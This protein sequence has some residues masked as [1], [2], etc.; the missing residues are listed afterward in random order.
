[1]NQPS[2]NRK[3]RWPHW[4]PCVVLAAG[5]F[6]TSGVMVYGQAAP[7]TTVKP[8][9][10]PPKVDPITAG[11]ASSDAAQ[12][13]KAVDTMRALFE[14]DTA[15]AA[16]KFKQ[17]WLKLLLET[18]HY[19]EV[20]DL[21]PKA[22]LNLAADMGA[23]EQ[24]QRAR[25]QA[26]IALG[27][28]E[29]ALANAK[30]LYN[31]ATMKGTAEAIM[32]VVQCLNLNP[33]ADANRLDRFKAQQLLGTNDEPA[34]QAL[35]KGPAVLA[36]IKVDGQQYDAAI[37]QLSGEDYT[38]LISRGNLL[39]LAD[40]PKEA[41]EVFERAYMIADNNQLNAASEN[42]ARAMRAEDGNVAR[43]NAWAL[44]IRPKSAATQPGA[45]TSSTKG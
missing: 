20:L 12:Q 29:Q 16:G 6:V 45:T 36:S 21:S 11:L 39:L 5:F 41:Q 25:V 30:G 38:S 23:V 34:M 8:K 17:E 27:K 7:P 22:I 32:L 18:K 13:Q 33:S 40:R 9:P 43:A 35:A 31:V 1:M 42:L 10:E 24:V 15:K 37:R 26:L 19:Q 28:P 44:S 4:V 2:R 14:S 3:Q